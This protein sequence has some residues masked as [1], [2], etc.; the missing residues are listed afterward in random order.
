MWKKIFNSVWSFA[1]YIFSLLSIMLNTWIAG[2]NQGEES[3]N[4]PLG[5]KP[6]QLCS[7][8]LIRLRLLA[9]TS[10]SLSFCVP[11]V[12]KSVGALS[13]IPKIQFLLASTRMCNTAREVGKVTVNLGLEAGGKMKAWMDEKK[14]F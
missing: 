4:I 6:Y 9:C 7:F 5:L 3:S 10:S 12:L 8:F 13:L 2:V 11:A 1:H 14:P